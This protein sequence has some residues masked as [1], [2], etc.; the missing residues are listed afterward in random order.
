[1]KPGLFRGWAALA[2]CFVGYGSAP[3][4]DAAGANDTTV[5]VNYSQGETQLGTVRQGEQ[6]FVDHDYRFSQISPEILGLQFT[7]R[8]FDSGGLVTIDIPAGVKVWVMTG[9]GG[10]GES[11]RNAAVALG[12]VRI[13]SPTSIQRAQENLPAAV[14]SQK[15]P[16]AKRISI[17]G[18]GYFGLVV[19]ASHL[20]IKS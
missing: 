11:A 14:Y 10:L 4:C 3:R 12:L 7:K 15:F 2:V 20:T 1:M 5:V 13:D 19:L 6:F 8:R 17:Q 9:D 18:A 16:Q